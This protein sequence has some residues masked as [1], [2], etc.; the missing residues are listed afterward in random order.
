MK[1]HPVKQCNRVKTRPQDLI[2]KD[3]RN[4]NAKINL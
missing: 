3:A 2:Y 4:Q 1:L